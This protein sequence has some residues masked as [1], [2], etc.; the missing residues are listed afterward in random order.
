MVFDGYGSS[1]KDH[2]HLRRTKNACCDIQIRSDLKNIVPREKFL[3][4]KHNKAQLILHLAETFQ[5]SRISVQQCSDDADTYIVCAALNEA[6]ES[7][8]EVR[9]EDTD[10]MVMLV[11]HRA[12]HPVFLTTA[13]RHILRCRKDPGGPP[14]EVP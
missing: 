1:T 10:V 8:V 11:H 5:R 2:D 7:S 3:D 12:N 14:G 13:K 9:A 4:N 6:I